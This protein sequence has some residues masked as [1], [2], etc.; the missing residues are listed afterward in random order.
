[1]SQRSIVRELGCIGHFIAAKNCLF[2]RHTQ[3]GSKYRVST[4]GDYYVDDKRQTIGAGDSDYFETY[5]FRTTGKP[6][7]GSEGCG[8]VEVAEWSEIDGNRSATA[9]EAQLCHEA[10]VNKYRALL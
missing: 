6:A 5:V 9:G 4:V 1:M 2:R 3:V 8:C 10:F 7:K